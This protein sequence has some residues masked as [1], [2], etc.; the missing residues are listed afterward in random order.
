MTPDVFTQMLALLEGLPPTAK[1]IGVSLVVLIITASI[2]SSILNESIRK[3]TAAGETIAPALL[4]LATV[5]NFIAGNLD[6]FIQ[7]GRMARGLPVQNTVPVQPVG[8][9]LTLAPEVKDDS[10]PK[11]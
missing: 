11:V 6:K 7:L 4:T 8:G 1:I 2:A 3:R 10:K 9:S 5:L